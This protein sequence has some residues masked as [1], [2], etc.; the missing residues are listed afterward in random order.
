M[1]SLLRFVLSITLALASAFTVVVPTLAAVA[2]PLD[3][4]TED[5]ILGAATILLNA[6]VAQPGAIFQSIELREPAK[7]VVLAF[8]SGNSVLR[9]ATVFFRQNKQSYKCVVDLSAGTFTTPQLIPI[10]DGQLGLTITEVSDFT[11]AFQDPAFLAAL[12]KRG[13]TTPEQLS[14]VFVT[15]LTPGTFG[16]PEETHRI[17][18]AQMYYRAGAATNLYAK[19]VEGVQAILDLDDRVVVKVIDTGTVPLPAMTHEF[20]EASVAARYGLRPA[21]NPLRISQPSG[22]NITFAG[23]FVQWQKWRFHVRFDRRPGT[24]ISLVTYDGR[25]VMYQGSLAEI[26]VPYQDPDQN[27]FYR[28]YMDA[29][30]FGAGL[31]AS[32]LKRGLDVPDNAILLD[33]LVS[34][35]IPVPDLPV[36]PLPLP[37]VVGVFERLTSNP[38]WRHFELFA[39]PTPAYEGRA[40]VEL[41]IRTISQVGNYDYLFDWVFNQSGA[42]RVD[43]ALTGIDAPKAVRSTRWSPG[44]AD[45]RFGALVAPNLVAP[46]HSHFFNF[47]VDLDVDGRSN[48]FVLGR[49]ERQSDVPGPRKSVWSVEDKTL[50]RERDGRLDDDHALWKVINPSHTN[51][52]GYPTGY[53]LETHSAVEPLLKKADYKRARFIDH[54]LWITRFAPDERFAAGDTPNQNPGEPGL[55]RYQQDNQSITNE[56]LVLW[57]TLGHHHVTAA[58]DFPVLSLE[59]MTFKL[60]PVN[61]FDRNPALDLRRAPFES[62]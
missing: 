28:T 58:E 30:E 36:V 39:G 19:P 37:Q 34:A 32:P 20:D 40:E 52:N 35:A 22:S 24:V 1:P 61:F 44:S 45:T 55:P 26:F 27:W 13:I 8:Q 14:Q 38:A 12:A 15:P 3:P 4:L 29:G 18:K 60:K 31:L 53:L 5:E 43:V 51:A 62:N 46:N 41:V 9:S 56:D 48:R 23:N 10:S 17:V 33:A 50:T 59:P 16:L 47:R 21:L 6:G 2:H 57:V 7:E 11:F 42:I 54:T 25:P 49:L